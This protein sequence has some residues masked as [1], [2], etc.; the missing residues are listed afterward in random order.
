MADLERIIQR[1]R[2]QISRAEPILFV[3]AGFSLEAT[4]ADGQKIP[5]TDQLANE[6]WDVAFPDQEFDTTTR[7][8]DA[9]YAAKS[10]NPKEL[11]R[12]IQRRL[13]VDGESLPDFYSQWFGVP[14]DRCYS[15]NIDDLEI[16]VSRRFPID[17]GISS[18][19]ATSGVSHGDTRPGRLEVVHLNG[20]V[21]D[22][23]DDLTFSNVDYGNRLATPD[24]WMIRC[25]TDLIARPI[26]FV[27][28]ELDESTLWQHLEYR[29]N[30]G[31]RGTRELRPGSVLVSPSLNPARQLLLNE[32]NIEWVPQTAQE[33]AEQV[34]SQMGP[35]VNAGREAATFKLDAERRVATPKLVSELASVNIDKSTEYLLGQEPDWSDLHQGRAI[36]REVDDEIIKQAKAILSNKVASVP[37]ILDGTAGSGKSTSLMRL[38]LELS[39]QGIPC[40]WIDESSNIEV[41][42]VRDLARDGEEPVA[43]LV[44][45]CDLFGRI[46]TGWARELPLIRPGI[47]VVCAVRSSKVDGL[48]D[49]DTLGGVEPIEITM[50]PLADA[51]IESLIGVLGRENRLGI[52]RNKRHNEQVEAFRKEAGRQLIV[53]MYQATSG[54]RFQEKVIE[55]YSQLPDIQRFIYG[56][57][58]FV[59]SQRY[60]LTL[61]ELLA[62]SG[63][64]DNPTL[65][66]IEQ[67]ISRHILVRS[68]KYSGYTTRHR[69][70]AEQITSS[71]AFRSEMKETL[72]AV[73]FALASHL[74]PN[75]PRTSRQ[76]RRW[77]WFIRH[78]FMMH[79]AS[80]QEGRELYTHLESLLNWDFQYWLQRGSLEVEEG[81]LSLAT[82]F[83]GQAKSM[84]PDDGYVATEWAYL[85]MKRAATYP[86]HVDANGWFSEGYGTL[87]SQTES[88][89]QRDEYPFHILGSQTLAWVR[90]KQL[91]MMEKR[92]LLEETKELVNS[93]L[94]LHSRSQELAQL[95]KDLQEEWL[96]TAVED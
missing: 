85:L 30:K 95:S 54:E 17:R 35:A 25:L 21:T 48:L 26:V 6:F 36:R 8:G 29:K 62:A 64:T 3:G 63:N 39:G 45:D 24:H 87:R 14:W 51:D 71:R 75:E 96:M 46:T 84:A 86:S 43:I 1:L 33:F 27:G 22:N 40:Y 53:A 34:L 93:G 72:E 10:Q 59:S 28:T 32:L 77:I 89:G 70:L 67:M 50:P 15:L 19:S 42:R 57:V 91:P 23:L 65:N 13:S 18:V 52:L 79:F 61:D 44:D 78:E 74:K 88:R 4:A 80:P 55:E 58:A 94:K 5:R 16:A 9:F 66:A 92:S 12:V 56:I 47:L 31:A 49:S 82:N 11:A 76:W 73:Y 7:L 83:L 2:S 68:D 38:G 90:S 20:T 41:Y 69:F 81:D 60:R 37:M